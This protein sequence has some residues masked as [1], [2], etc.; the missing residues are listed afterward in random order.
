MGQAGC[1]DSSNARSWKLAKQAASHCH[2]NFTT[3]I[4]TAK[5]EKKGIT[6]QQI[7]TWLSCC[8]NFIGCFAENELKNISITSFPAFLI[9]NI[10]PNTSQGSHWIAVGIFK[11]TIEIFDPLGFDIFNWNQIPCNL[12]EFL[13]NMSVTRRVKTASKIQSGG[14]LCGFYALFYVIVRKFISFECL[15]KLFCTTFLS[16]NDKILYNFFKHD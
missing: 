8:P 9:I 5:K 13:H 4:K 16:R 11:D 14:F 15:Q 7:T 12:L 1:S 6:D 2:E 10:D 3:E